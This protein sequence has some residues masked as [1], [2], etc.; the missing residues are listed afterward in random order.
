[1]TRSLTSPPPPIT[2]DAAQAMSASDRQERKA[3]VLTSHTPSR[4]RSIADAVVIKDGDPFFICPPDGEVPLD[5]EH[6]FGLYHHDTRY[7][8]GYELRI[9]G[10]AANPLAATAV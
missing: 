4:V 9:A 2:R 6:G 1:M 7:L 5:G 10:V 8:A 3:R